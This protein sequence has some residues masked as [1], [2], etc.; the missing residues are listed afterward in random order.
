[1]PGSADRVGC[2]RETSKESSRVDKYAIWFY[3]TSVSVVIGT[4][5]TTTGKGKGKGRGKRTGKVPLEQA[6]KAQ[7]WSRGIA[8]LFL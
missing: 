5:C 3:S 2:L 7:R 6:T 4:Y 8:L 1:M